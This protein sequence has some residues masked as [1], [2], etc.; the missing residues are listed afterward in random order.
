M[1][2]PSHCRPPRRAP[3]GLASASAARGKGPSRTRAGTRSLRGEGRRTRACV[4]SRPLGTSPRG[5]GGARMPPHGAATGAVCGS[6]DVRAAGS[7]PTT[8]RAGRLPSRISRSTIRRT[9]RLGRP[10]QEYVALRTRSRLAANS[11]PYCCLRAA[12]TLAQSARNCSVA[13]LTIPVPWKEGL[14]VHT[15]TLNG[16][17]SCRMPSLNAW[18]ACFDAGAATVS[19]AVTHASGPGDARGVRT[20]VGGERGGLD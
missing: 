12:G 19:T 13:P 18:R 7:L 14:T 3:G 6:E 15:C 11:D 2:K 20:R 16:A 9:T 8:S 1:F 17:S 4:S 10:L 5:E